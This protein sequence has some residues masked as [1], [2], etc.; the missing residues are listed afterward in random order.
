MGRPIYPSIE[1]MTRPETL[2][3]LV[4]QPIFQ[5]HLVPFQTAG[6]SSTESQFLAVE[7][8]NTEH[9]RYILKRLVWEKDWVMQMTDDQHWR[10]I[11]ICQHGLLD[12]L[13]EEIDHT[14]IA[15]AADGPGYALLM[16][17]VSHTLFPDET[18]LS[19]ADHAFNLEAMAAFHATFWEDDAL[20]NPDFNL[21][22]PAN[23]FTHT[24]PEKFRRIAA[25]NPALV[26]DTA[27]EGWRLLPTFVDA[28]VFDL[29]QS[30]AHNPQPLCKALANYPQTLVHGDWRAPNFGIERNGRSQL[31]LLDWARPT[32]TAPA[33]DL[34]YYLVC[35][36]HLLPVSQATT[37]AL[38]KQQ[39]ARRLGDRFDESWWQPQ[40]ELSLLG[41]LLMIGC[42]QAFN[43]AQS[44]NEAAR[45]QSQATF[46]WWSGQA[47]AAAR[48]LAY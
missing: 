33:V 3:H 17:N 30:L 12:R 25:V 27:L 31:N 37:I 47:R 9:P 26:I 45:K 1:E 16:R 21:C 6:H 2:S 41:A 38:Y 24:A 36:W 46:A 23:L 5:T 13:P 28:D 44:D 39:L 19:K 15:C 32:P 29:V 10:A 22:S 4:Q 8:D 18:F 48:W 11:T 14:I 34:A 42:F 7:T 40:L 43:T 35:G 20:Q